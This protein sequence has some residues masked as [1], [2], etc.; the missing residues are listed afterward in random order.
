MHDTQDAMKNTFTFIIYF[1]PTLVL[2]RAFNIGFYLFTNNG[3]STIY[4][5]WFIN[6]FDHWQLGLVLIFISLI[7]VKRR[8]ELLAIGLGLFIEDLTFII[9]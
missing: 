5:N 8:A 4:N 1:L 6:T 9:K 3:T 2:S 7:Y